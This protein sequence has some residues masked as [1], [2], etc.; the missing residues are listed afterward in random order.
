MYDCQVQRKYQKTTTNWSEMFP[1]FLPVNHFCSVV[2]SFLFLFSN[3][4]HRNASAAAN[5]PACVWYASTPAKQQSYT[6]C[7]CFSYI[8]KGIRWNQ[9]SLLLLPVR[10]SS[11]FFTEDKRENKYYLDEQWEEL[12]RFMSVCVCV[13]WKWFCH[14]KRCFPTVLAISVE[15]TN[16]W[17]FIRNRMC[18]RY[19][20]CVDFFYN[21]LICRKSATL[22]C[23]LV[24]WFIQRYGYFDQRLWFE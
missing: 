4:S 12:V 9:N 8:F 2:C 11:F 10:V 5:F 24:D 13:V 6:M 21:I 7:A 18:D 1:W 20:I 16:L 19:D 14:R 3:H 23:E 17:L 22:C 15:L